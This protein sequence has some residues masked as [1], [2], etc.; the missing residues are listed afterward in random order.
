MTMRSDCLP[1]GIF[2][3]TYAAQLTLH[4]MR[5]LQRT[6]PAEARHK[7][8][9]LDQVRQAQESGLLAHDDFRIHRRQ[10]RPLQRNG[11]NRLLVDLKQK[12]FAVSVEALT[13]ALERSTAERMER[14]RYAHKTLRRDTRASILS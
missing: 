11:A 6:T 9:Q 7:L 12:P 14:V 8:R 2:A 4:L 5:P 1:G 3:L 13:H 10:V